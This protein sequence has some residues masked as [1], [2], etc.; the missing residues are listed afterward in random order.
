MFIATP[1][2][3]SKRRCR[4]TGKLRCISLASWSRPDTRW[5]RSRPTYNRPP[6]D[7]RDTTHPKRNDKNFMRVNFLV[8]FSI[9]LDMLKS[10]LLRVRDIFAGAAMDAW[11]EIAMSLRGAYLAMHRQA[12]GEFARYGITA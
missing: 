3:G 8:D 9:S 10:S 11:H 2:P 1:P 7:T 4:V 12:D 5:P 6:A